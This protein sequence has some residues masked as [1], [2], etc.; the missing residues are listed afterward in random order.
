MDISVTYM[1]PTAVLYARA[2]GPYEQSVE[3]AWGRMLSWLDLRR[4]RARTPRGFGI[5]NDN[6]RSVHPGQR[7]Y[8]ACIELQPG[9]VSDSQ[10]GIESKMTPGGAFAVARV[11]GPHAA[12][13]RAFKYL[14]SEWVPKHGLTVDEDRPHLEIYLNDPATTPADQLLTDVCVPVVP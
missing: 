7:R 9:L 5:I 6:P 8:D 13:S 14:R 4:V 10:A 11:R 2:S 12:I 3:E 1:K